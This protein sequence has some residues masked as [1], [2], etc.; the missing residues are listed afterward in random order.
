MRTHAVSEC[1]ECESLQEGSSAVL[2]LQALPR[3]RSLGFLNRT[4]LLDWPS[5]ASYC[6][7][8]ATTRPGVHPSVSPP[9][10]SN[11]HSVAPSRRSQTLENSD[12]PP[13][14][15]ARIQQLED[16]AE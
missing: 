3:L 7:Y 5:Q 6:C 1:L 13:F 8:N 16:S 4:F 9:Y 15:A 12:G 10:L 11:R 2:L 14:T